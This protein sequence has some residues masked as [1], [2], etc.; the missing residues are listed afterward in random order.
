MAP[1][2]VV[3]HSSRGPEF[4]RCHE[5]A[6]LRSVA[7]AIARCKGVEFRGLYDPTRRDT[8]PLFFV[9]D[10]TL[11]RRDADRLGIR[12]PH[13]LFGGVVPH[14]FVKTKIVTHELVAPTA[15]RPDGWSDDFPRRIRRGVLPGHSAFARDDAREAVRRLLRRGPVRAKLPR[16][17]GARDQRTLRSL[18]DAEA[19]LE[20]LSDDELA[21]HGILFEVNLEPVSTL[22]VGQVT[23]DDL[24]VTYHGRQW[25]G[26]DNAGRSV[27]GGSELTCVRGGWEAIARLGVPRATRTAIWQAR[28]YDATTDTYG[29]IASRRNY[30]VGQGTDAA[31]HAHSGVF[32]ASWRAGGASPAELAAL[33]LLARS[34]SIHVVRAATVEEYGADAAPPRDAVV[35][36]H[37]MDEQ[38]GP[39]VRYTVIRETRERAA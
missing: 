21:R 35:Q 38:A 33:Q 13:D 39:L 29:I 3:L 30:D 19:L 6:T 31:G 15:A 11:V 32:E 14:A 37:G 1:N 7:E 17:A 20:Q 12:G 18:A 36:F 23:L 9:P 28:T 34:P 27:Y 24:T 2:P 22:S 26:R 4:W 25:L 10:D 16:S 8:E 5:G